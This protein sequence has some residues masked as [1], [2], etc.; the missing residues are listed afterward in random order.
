MA[1]SILNLDKLA[2]Q[3]AQ[4]IVQDVLKEAQKEA[5]KEASKQG[6]SQEETKIAIQGLQKKRIETLGRLSTKALG[7]LQSQGV[8]ACMLFLY[9][10]SSDESKVAPSI[11][12]QL[13]KALEEIPGLS[14]I[15][16]DNASEALS[17]FTEQVAG[18]SLDTLLLIRDLYEQTLIYARYG[19]KAAKGE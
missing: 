11:R 7:V 14:N 10:R 12:R 15:P 16:N 3:T 1:T 9:S 18:N 8:Y 13:L 5:E 6:K 17:F 4:A 2:A 19:A